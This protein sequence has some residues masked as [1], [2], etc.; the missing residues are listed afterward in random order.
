MKAVRIV[1]EHGYQPPGNFRVRLGKVADD[2]I[3]RKGARK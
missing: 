2:P 1:V 3:V